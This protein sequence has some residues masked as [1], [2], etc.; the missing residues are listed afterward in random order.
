M[1]SGEL[2]STEA[3]VT[4]AQI[5]QLAGVTRA[6]V[7]N[8]RRRF[9]DFPRPAGGSIG[10][11]TFALSDVETWLRR[12]GKGLDVSDEVRLWHRLRTVDDSDLARIIAQV[13]AHLVGTTRSPALLD[14]SLLD[15]LGQQAA[16]RTP[17][18]LLEDL[19]TRYLAS[20]SRTTG[21]TP[22][23]LAELLWATIRTFA[24]I[25]ETGAVFDPSCGTGNLL[26]Q[27]GAFGLRHYYGQDIDETA[28]A[29]T[30]ARGALAYNDG[31][32][33]EVRVESGDSLMTDRFP[34]LQADLVVC[35]PPVGV[36]EWGHDQ[37]LIDP[38]WEFGVPPRGESELAW[39]QHCLAHTAPGGVAALI[40]PPIVAARRS[41]RKIR[42]E[43]VRRS[44]VHAV[45]ALP[46]GFAANHAGGMH[47]WLLRRPAGGESEPVA[48]RMVDLSQSSDALT[49]LHDNRY[50]A[51]VPAIDLLDDD[52][53][54]SPNRHVLPPEPDYYAELDTLCTQLGDMFRALPHSLPRHEAGE[55]PVR[56]AHLVTVA[57]LLRAGHVE[58]V[59]GGI[60]SVN[61]DLDDAFIQA[62]MAA[63]G[64]RRRSTTGTG[65]FRSDLR[66]IVIPQLSL[67][68]QR[69]Y[70]AALDRVAQFRAAVRAVAEAGE[71]AAVLAS[72]GLTTGSLVPYTVGSAPSGESE[73]KS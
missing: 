17:S 53:D 5:A 43:L 1:E 32:R 66:A 28:V 16:Q 61:P 69:A 50:T 51:V 18:E 34:N 26:L 45:V 39:V 23:P 44:A 52:V 65:S 15:E 21:T 19:H 22:T 68:D 73:G 41:G 14:R 13:G 67:A 24:S 11:P 29:I 3:A 25:P 37:L 64:D 57:D 47:L 9:P 63:G 40:L 71:R 59:D 10:S 31:D 33:Q 36:R 7:S 4:A 46:Q 2:E 20:S 72:D 48:V 70:A 12:Q 42:A 30:A 6:A 56:S 35:E 8:W 54:L 62:Y 55:T 58:L 27:A 49:D 60:R 38:R